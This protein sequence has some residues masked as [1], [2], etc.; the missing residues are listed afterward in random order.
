MAEYGKYGFRGVVVKPYKVEELIR[1]L[2]RVLAAD[3]ALR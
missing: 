2:Q 1:E 3:A